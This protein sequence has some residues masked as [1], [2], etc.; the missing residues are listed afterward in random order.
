MAVVTK[1][2]VVRLHD[3]DSTVLDEFKGR[4][5]LQF[6]DDPEVQQEG[7]ARIVDEPDGKSQTLGGAEA[8]FFVYA[9][10]AAI[11]AT[12]LVVREFRERGILFSVEQLADASTAST[13]QNDKR[14]MTKGQR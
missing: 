1:K 6:R 13:V 8:F 12:N 7:N 9:G 2:L 14:G 11:A 4:L 10:T 3:P 5:Q